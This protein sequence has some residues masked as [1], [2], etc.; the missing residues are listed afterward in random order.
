MRFF[1]FFFILGDAHFQFLWQGSS[2]Y[3]LLPIQVM[4]DDPE[5]GEVWERYST[6]D[7][8]HASGKQ[9]WW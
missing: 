4:V 8:I 1:S 3:V 2:I 6:G 9:G 7:S 5:N